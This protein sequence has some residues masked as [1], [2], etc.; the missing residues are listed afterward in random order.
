VTGFGLVSRHVGDGAPCLVIAEVG[1]AH[2]GSL[3]QAHAYIDAVADAGVGAVKFQCHIARDESTKDEKWRVRPDWPQD[4][5]RYAYWVR[6]AFT[7][8]Q[9]IELREH[10]TARNLEFLC[11]PFG[12]EAVEMLEPLVPAWKIPSGEM[13]NEPLLI[14]ITETE[15]PVILST[16]M[17]TEDELKGTVGKWGWREWAVMQCTSMYPCPPDRVGLANLQVLDQEYGVPV[18]LS[19]HSG[20]IF[21]GLGAVAV[22]CDLLEVHVC[23]SRQEFGFDV[24][25]SVTVEELAYLVEGVRFLEAARAP[26]MKDQLAL[27]E[28]GGMRELFMEKWRRKQ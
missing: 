24:P 27:E 18:G 28:L 7:R 14:A 8:P 21:A 10:A 17:S 22:G 12:V 16:G 2:D 5:S 23:F 6:T 4:D 19:D 3:G 11:S 26:V 20:T 13:L 25:A 15:K 1:L 9:W